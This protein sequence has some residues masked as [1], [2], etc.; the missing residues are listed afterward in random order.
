MIQQT[1]PI[2]PEEREK[3]T[4]LAVKQRKV[5]MVSACIS[6]LSAILILLFGDY[7]LLM[8]R[9]ETQGVPYTKVF[10]YASKSD[11]A[12]FDITAV[13]YVL[14]WISIVFLAMSLLLVYK[15][16]SGQVVKICTIAFIVNAVTLVLL[17][18]FAYA[19]GAEFITRY[20]SALPISYILIIPGAASFSGFLVAYQYQATK[21]KLNT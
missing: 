13:L 11:K 7:I 9:T 20:I 4:K 6:I 2:T 8:T 1:T 5:F 21:K 14:T 17:M 12:V 15:K 10:E 18:A 16:E 3:L 19:C